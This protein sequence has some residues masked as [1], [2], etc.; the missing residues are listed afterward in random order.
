MKNLLVTNGTLQASLTALTRGDY[1]IVKADGS[2]ASSLPTTGMYK[3]VVGLGDGKVIEG[4]WLN[5]DNHKGVKNNYAPGDVKKIAVFAKDLDATL[6]VDAEIHIQTQ[7]KSALSGLDYQ[8]FV[9]VVPVVSTTQDLESVKT[10]LKK[11]IDSVVSRINAYFPTPVLKVTA[12]ATKDGDVTS[13]LDFESLNTDFNFYVNFGGAISGTTIETNALTFGTKD[14]IVA[15][16]KEMAVATFGYN[17]SFEAGDKAYGDVFVAAEIYEKA[18]TVTSGTKAEGF[19]IVVVTSTAPSGESMPLN[20][21]AANVEQW[22]AF[23]N[24]KTIVAK[25]D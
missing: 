2:I 22:I 17:P 16:E 23:P 11:Q 8:E 4:L 25:I 7:P 21:G 3:Y 12:G 15:L 5:A 1:A 14:E 13:W 19:H 6:R 24:T 9:A 10:S 18:S 20:A